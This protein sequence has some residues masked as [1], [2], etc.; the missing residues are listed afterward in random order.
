M[1]CD[2]AEVCIYIGHIL[3][4]KLVV[5]ATVASKCKVYLMLSCAFSSNYMYLN[6]S[7][8]AFVHV[9]IGSMHGHWT[10]I[11]FFL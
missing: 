8:I 9:H 2:N 11:Y 5:I 10:M 6:A 1:G 7:F 4:C 3:I